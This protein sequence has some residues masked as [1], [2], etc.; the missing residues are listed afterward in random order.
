MDTPFSLRLILD[1][2]EVIVALVAGCAAI[3]GIV[4]FICSIHDRNKKVDGYDMQI[5]EVQK[6][7]TDLKMDTDHE[8][9]EIKKEQRVITNAVLAILQGLSQLNCNG[10]VTEAK[11]E[12]TEFLNER[13]HE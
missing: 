4:K 8:L 3:Y 9:K 12:L 6:S 7:I 5:Q 13:A 11:D 2:L 10:P 1:I